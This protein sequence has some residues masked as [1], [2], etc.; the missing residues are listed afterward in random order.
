MFDMNFSP[1]TLLVLS[2]HIGKHSFSLLN[3]YFKVEM[4]VLSDFL[5]APPNNLNVYSLTV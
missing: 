1:S 5:P 3:L 4:V 2:F